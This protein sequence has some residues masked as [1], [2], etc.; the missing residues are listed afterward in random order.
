MSIISHLQEKNFLR[1]DYN[2]NFTKDDRAESELASAGPFL[3]IMLAGA[4]NLY[5]GPDL[6]YIPNQKL[7]AKA[8]GSTVGLMVSVGILSSGPVRALY[9]I[10]IKPRLEQGVRNLESNLEKIQF[11][12]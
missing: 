1:K 4:A 7:I 5:Y 3:I 8:A 6:S 2:L 10:V 9:D 11:N 12:F